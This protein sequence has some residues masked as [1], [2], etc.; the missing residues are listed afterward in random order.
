VK[1]TTIDKCVVEASIKPRVIKTDV[2]GVE[3]FV[4]QGAARTIRESKP[5]LTLEFNPFRLVPPDIRSASTS[6]S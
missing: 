2:G 5:V 4:L 1:T 6:L 3:L